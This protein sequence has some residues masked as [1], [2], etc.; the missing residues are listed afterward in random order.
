MDEM[1]AL[2]QGLQLAK[3][4]NFTTIEIETDST[5]LMEALH[6]AQPLYASI[7]NSCRLLM[8]KLG[9]PVI[10]HSFRQANQ[11]A[12]FLSK[13]GSKLTSSAQA[14]IFQYPP[15]PAIPLTKADLEGV[16]TTRGKS[17]I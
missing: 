7:S 13:M 6:H 8:K 14:T 15:A 12:D 11:V 9:N 17:K 16:T 2:L 10:R 3:D 1:E 4:N 5:D